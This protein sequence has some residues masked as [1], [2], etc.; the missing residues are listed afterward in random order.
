MGV[1]MLEKNIK[2]TP[3]SDFVELS[4]DPPVPSY[5]KIPDWFKSIKPE[6]KMSK[7]EMLEATGCPSR[8]SGT[9]KKCVPVLDSFTSG[10]L[11]CLP[12]DLEI[13]KVDDHHFV[14]WPMDRPTSKFMT[15][16][17][18]YRLSSFI[19][20]KDHDPYPW[21]VNTG[22]SIQTPKGYSTLITHPFNRFDLPFQTMTGIID[23][24]GLV[25]DNVV[26]LFF[27]KDFEGI[28]EKGTPI[29]Q[30]LPFKRD[31]WKSSKEKAPTAAQYYTN[32]FEI[33]SKVT[34]FYHNHI[35][36]KKQYR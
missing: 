18:P 28:I 35:W 6:I 16:E 5:T 14:F 15:Y 20:P 24:D 9:V 4:E 33:R 2:F 19:I 22:Y 13:K 27:H 3:Q 17:E 8:Y 11:I 36:T 29:A 23:T 30:L 26:T 10:Y 34:R 7:D 12:Q 25:L 1:C 21:R 31:N 32:F